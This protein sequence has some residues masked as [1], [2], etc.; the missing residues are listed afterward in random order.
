MGPTAG[1]DLGGTKIQAVVLDPDGELAGQGRTRT[2]VD[3]GAAAVVGAIGTA[4][5]GAASAAG[6]AAGDLAAVG[7]GS[8]GQIDQASGSVIGAAN[9]PGFEQPVALRDLVAEATGVQRVALDNDVNVGTL[10]EQRHGAGRGHDDLLAVFAG[11]GVGGGVVLGGR[12]RRG[13]TGAA[14]EIGHMVV[15]LGGDRCPCGRD[16]CMEAYAGR[17]SIERKA[18]QAAAAGRG[19]VLLDLMR[20]RGRSRMTS[21]V[22]AAA[23]EAGDELAH[24]LIDQAVAALAAAIA[25]SVNLL[26]VD[27]VVLGGGLAEK[28]GAPFTERVAGAMTPHLFASP[29]RV[30]VV[31]A[32]LGDLGGAIGAAELAR[33]PLGP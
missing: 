25:S 14:G 27:L 6:L 24:E 11:S 16:G 21:G 33:Q 4:L 3:G 8:P 12:L 32:A 22:I 1:I 17:I 31:G 19:T 18:R 7:L 20:E 9:L 10:A 23:L 15:V 13:L 2:P 26:D 28:L 30:E 29:P 5:A